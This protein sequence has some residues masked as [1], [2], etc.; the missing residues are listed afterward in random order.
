MAKVL[1]SNRRA[2][3]QYQILETFEAGMVLTGA[4][5]KSLRLG[6][7]GLTD[8]FVRLKQDEVFLENAWITA[9]QK[10]SLPSYDPRQPRKLLLKKSEI[11][12]FKQKLSKGLTVVPLKVYTTS[13]GLIKV[14]I[15]LAKGKRKYDKREAKRKKEIDQQVK[16]YLRTVHGDE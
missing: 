6:N 14:Q 10:A 11:A 7:A 3:H 12:T 9:Y 13:R 8:S 16:K 1:V 4:E 2:L 15:A 5:V